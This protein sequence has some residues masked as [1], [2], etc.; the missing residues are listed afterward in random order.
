[1]F[2]PM[3]VDKERVLLQISPLSFANFDTQFSL[4]FVGNRARLVYSGCKLPCFTALL[5]VSRELVPLV[6]GRPCTVVLSLCTSVKTR[7]GV[8]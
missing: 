6:S 4:E 8:S 3:N 7:H 5:A 2:C 1:M